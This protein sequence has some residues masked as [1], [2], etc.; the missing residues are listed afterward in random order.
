[1]L[2]YGKEVKM[3]NFDSY[4]DFEAYARSFCLDSK[5]I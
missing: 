4:E 5:G 1:M 3:R 2:T